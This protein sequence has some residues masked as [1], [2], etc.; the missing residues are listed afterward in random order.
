M[1][2]MENHYRNLWIQICIFSFGEFRI[3][4]SL[5]NTP[6]IKTLQVEYVVIFLGS[7]YI[8]TTHWFEILNLRYVS[9]VSYT[10]DFLQ[11]G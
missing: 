11:L 5:E 3:W 1:F 4:G 10:N 9:H 2:I 8:D 7:I 6:F